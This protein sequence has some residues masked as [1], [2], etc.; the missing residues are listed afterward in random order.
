M[1]PEEVRHDLIVTIVPKGA[2][3][4]ALRVSREAGAEGG[5]IVYGRGVGIHETRKILGVAIEP[6]KEMLLTVVPQTLSRQVVERI[7]EAAQLNVPG[8]GIAFVLA[9]NEVVGVC[10]LGSCSDSSGDTDGDAT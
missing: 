2:A 4:K 9:L 10:H 7:A 6:E 8:K 5:T 3:E 1:N